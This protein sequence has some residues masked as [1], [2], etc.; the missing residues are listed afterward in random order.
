MDLT[1]PNYMGLTAA[2][3]LPLRYLWDDTRCSRDFTA[4]PSAVLDAARSLSVRARMALCI[5]LYEWV[6]WRFDGLHDDPAPRQFL[7]AA[8]CASVDPRTIR[9]FELERNA[10]I[11]PVRGP[12]W[13]AI[14]WLRAALADGDA[15][16]V[17]VIDG[18]QYLTRLALHVVPEPARLQDWLDAVL[19]RLRC[20]HPYRPDDPFADL[21]G[22]RIGEHRGTLVGREVFDP[23]MPY[24]ADAGARWMAAWLSAARTAANPFLAT[25][26]FNNHASAP[27][28][29]DAVT[30]PQKPQEGWV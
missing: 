11:G 19:P 26:P 4:D 17:E 2:N 13:C 24:D 12:L 7:Q 18:L 6:V 30:D 20:H 28:S 9:F 22:R 25:N 10:W 15:K 27:P 23:C 16:P 21:L 1:C 14:T 8:W 3:R 5:A 29:Q